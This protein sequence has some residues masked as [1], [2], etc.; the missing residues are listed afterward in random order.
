MRLF[1]AGLWKFVAEAG[2]SVSTISRME[3]DVQDGLTSGMKPASKKPGFPEKVCKRHLKRLV[4]GLLSSGDFREV[5][6]GDAVF[7]RAVGS[8]DGRAA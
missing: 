5:T 8:V 4:Q 6:D 2:F 3:A 1:G 7:V